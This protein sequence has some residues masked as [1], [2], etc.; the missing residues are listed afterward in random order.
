MRRV[1]GLVDRHVPHAGSVPLQA[2]LLLFLE[3]VAF[4]V[5][6]QVGV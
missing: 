5:P 2:P 4:L 3:D 6:G 1:I